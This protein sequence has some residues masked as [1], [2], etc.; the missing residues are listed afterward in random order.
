MIRTR[1]V[2]LMAVAGCL[3]TLTAS[4]VFAQ[5]GMAESGIRRVATHK[6]IPLYPAASI[7]KGTSGVSVASIV[8]GLEGT[9]TSVAI[10]EAPDEAI[11]DAVRAALLS[12]K[13]PPVTI[14]G[15][16]RIE[17]MGVRGKVTFY[18]RITGGRGRVFHPEDMP[19]GPKPDPASGPPAA[20]PGG[21]PS[22]G[23]PGAPGAARPAAIVSLEGDADS[24]IGEAAFTAMAASKP[25]LLDIRER[26]DFRREHRPGAVNIPRNELAI[27][28]YIELEPTRP[29]VIDCT[30]TET[31]TCHS[32]ARLL[33]RG[34]KLSKVLILFP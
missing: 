17:S 21:R 6:L 3:V 2:A 26:D 14:G 27:R 20:S 31:S 7:A 18:F 8:S 10:L 19:G 30:F 32:A 22:S 15:A 16:D 28:A 24:E 34:P 33:R 1:H 5:A 4:E 29:V 23:Q 12:W 13:I 9:V 11:A 25:I